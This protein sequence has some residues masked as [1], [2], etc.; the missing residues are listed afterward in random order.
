MSQVN[1][2]RLLEGK[3]VG[4]YGKDE[5]TLFSD[6]LSHKQ[7]QM[8]WVQTYYCGTSDDKSCNYD[9]HILVWGPWVKGVSGNSEAK[10]FSGV[11]IY[12]CVDV[13]GS[14][15]EWEKVCQNCTVGNTI[16]ECGD[17][18]RS[19]GKVLTTNGYDIYMNDAQDHYDHDGDSTTRNDYTKSHAVT[20]G[21]NINEHICK[22]KAE[23]KCGKTPNELGT[24]VLVEKN[25]SGNVK[26][27]Y[28][29]DGAFAETEKTI[30]INTVCDSLNDFGEFVKFGSWNSVYDIYVKEKL[31]KTGCFV[32]S[33]TYSS[34]NDNNWDFTDVCLKCKDGTSYDQS[35]DECVSDSD[36]LGSGGGSDS[37]GG[38]EPAPA[39]EQEICGGVKCNAAN[40]GKYIFCAEKKEDT[41]VYKCQ[42]GIWTE[43]DSYAYCCKNDCSKPRS[44]QFVNGGSWTP[45]SGHELWFATTSRINGNAWWFESTN[46]SKNCTI[47]KD[48][49]KYNKKTQKC[50]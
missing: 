27:W 35:K 49:T 21:N 32:S 42:S 29:K 16:P 13:F 34:E 36:N 28:A 9:M 1:A 23:K 18:Q 10:M 31:S 46:L 11:H 2:K 19:W 25:D 6:Y 38:S 30:F 44:T 37:G 47:C 43:E 33:R 40:N 8:S 15:D 48:G 26:T 14:E 17:S 20:F 4:W 12:K 22:K 39:V 7:G 3:G 41:Y 50:E 24:N 45:E 5:I